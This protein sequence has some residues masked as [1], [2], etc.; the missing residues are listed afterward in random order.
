[1]A[2]SAP[3][4]KS[5]PA[6]AAPRK[7]SRLRG[8]LAVLGV[9]LAVLLLAAAWA[10]C[11]TSQKWSAFRKRHD[12]RL[13]RAKAAGGAREPLTGPALPG[14]AWD[15][16]APALARLKESRRPRGLATQ[17]LQK[18]DDAEKNAAARE[19]LAESAEPLGAI[20]LGVKRGSSLFPMKWDLGMQA[21]LPGLLALQEAAS[22]LAYSARERAA[23]GDVDGALDD[24]SAAVQLGIDTVRAPTLISAMIGAALIK[25]GVDEAVRLVARPDLKPEQAARLYRMMAAADALYPGFHA[26]LETETAVAHQTLLRLEAGGDPNDASREQRDPALGRWSVW[27]LVGQGAEAWNEFAD[28]P[29]QGD[30]LAYPEAEKFYQETVDRLVDTWNPIVKSALPGLVS[31]DRSLRERRV[32][33]R[34]VAAAALL[35]LGK[36]TAD[37]EWPIDPFTL[38]PLLLQEADGVRRIRSLGRDGLENAKGSWSPTSKDEDPVLEIAK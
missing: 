36:G 14:N 37:P 18:P 1:M 10:G 24:V 8:C 21:E 17:A 35:R 19:Y 6:P 26:V 28:A 34:L 15:D 3:E 31:C 30:K 20:R 11:S 12:E 32:H 27:F 9:L 7:R 25:M 13:A 16:Y 4:P 23:K 38:K 2:E 33:L 22:L 29:L 5:T